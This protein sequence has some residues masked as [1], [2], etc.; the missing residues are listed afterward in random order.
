MCAIPFHCNADP[1]ITVMR[2]FVEAYYVYK[3]YQQ[4]YFMYFASINKKNLIP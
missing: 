1:E 3:P 2:S 4:D